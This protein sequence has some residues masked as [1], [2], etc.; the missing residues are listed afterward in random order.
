MKRVNI[1]EISDRV[2]LLNLYLTQAIVL[3]AACVL[4]WW[5]G[6]FNLNLWESESWTVWLWGIAA[7]LVIVCVD[8]VLSRF[9]PDFML[10][11]G[12]INEK[13]FRNRPMWHIFVMTLVIAVCEEL[14]FRGALQPV[15]GIFWTSILFTLIHFRYLKQWMMTIL[16][17]C[18][19]LGL[20]G[21]VVWTGSLV[22]STVAHFV[23]D[24]SL[25][26]LLRSGRLDEF[27]K[28]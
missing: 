25:G 3:T 18:I 22:T 27:I 26:V 16:V 6:R 1:E 9:F 23:V 21:L 24:F 19:S 14:L 12:G 8:L 5:Q 2:L 17:F 10:D 15:L 11:D 20:G 4:L 13:L 7:G 28:R